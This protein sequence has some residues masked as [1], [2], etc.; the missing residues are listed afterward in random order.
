MGGVE[1]SGQ[2]AAT[3]AAS[4]SQDERRGLD[5]ALLIPLGNG[6]NVVHGNRHRE[7]QAHDGKADDKGLSKNR[8]A[9]E[10]WKQRHEHIEQEDMPGENL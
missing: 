3:A 5:S 9:L 1:P 8:L 7:E 2:G 4:G 6:G 10:L